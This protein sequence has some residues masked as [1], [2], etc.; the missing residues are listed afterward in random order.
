MFVAFNYG[1]LNVGSLTLGLLAWVLPSISIM[2]HKKE[3]H[4]NW[5]IYSLLSVSACSVSLWFQMLYNHHLVQIEDWSALMDTTGALVMV[6]TVLVVV[7]VV[8]NTA[9]VWMNN[10]KV[11]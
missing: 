5:F 2:K 11:Y 8:L 3:N 10:K 9:N 7:T 4:R 1:L 6:A